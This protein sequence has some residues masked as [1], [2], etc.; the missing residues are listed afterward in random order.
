MDKEKTYT[1]SEVASMMGVAPSTLRYYDKE[2]L[3]PFVERKNGIRIF[4]DR[5]FAALRILNCLKNT[6]MPIKDIKEYFELTK[7]GDAS[8]KER[9]AIILKQKQ[10]LENQM[11]FLRQNMKELEYKEWYYDT[12]IAAGTES[13]HKGHSC[14]PTLEP[15]TIP[16]KE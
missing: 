8:L 7:L 3:L 15:D 1:I 12:A 9:Q 13:I 5:D 4:K 6:G 2:G 16:D 14:S 11:E 10:S